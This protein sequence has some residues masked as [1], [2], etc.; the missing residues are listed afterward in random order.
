MANAV[1]IF[2]S[3]S[4][5]FFVGVCVFSLAILS[6]F[7]VRQLPYRADRDVS[8]LFYLWAALVNNVNAAGALLGAGVAAAT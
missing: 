5:L 6:S 7:S 4:I 3:L 2:I 1:N 8:C